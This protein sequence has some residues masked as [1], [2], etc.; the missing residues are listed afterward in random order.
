[1]YCRSCVETS[2]SVWSVLEQCMHR[3]ND[4]FSFYSWREEMRCRS[5]RAKREG[6]RGQWAMEG[7]GIRGKGLEVGPLV[8]AW[9]R[10]AT[11][12]A[13]GRKLEEDRGT[14]CR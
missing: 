7:Q 6:D 11:R 2:I 12:A 8:G 10:P 4:Q 14:H 3:D 5:V 9:I 1:M 13:G